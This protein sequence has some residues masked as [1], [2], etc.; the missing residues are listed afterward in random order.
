ME[1]MISHRLSNV[2][3]AIQDKSLVGAVIRPRVW[4]SLRFQAMELRRILRHI[5][6]WRLGIEAEKANRGASLI[7]QSATG[8]T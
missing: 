1:S 4:P 6:G 2:V 5:N 7:R 8:G 3:F